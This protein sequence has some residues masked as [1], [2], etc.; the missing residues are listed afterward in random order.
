[1]ASAQVTGQPSGELD[2]SR[3]SDDTLL[4]RLTGSWR[5]QN[6]LPSATQIQQQVEAD[7]QIRRLCFDTDGVTDWDSGLLTFLLNLQDQFAQ[8]QLA[9]D[10][11]GLPEGVKEASR[12]C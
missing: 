4:V 2:V 6:E 3:L 8:R 9:V 10:R 1:M 12:S 5:I 7:D 11:A